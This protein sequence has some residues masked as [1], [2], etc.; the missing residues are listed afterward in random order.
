MHPSVERRGAGPA[1]RLRLAICTEAGHAFIRGAQ[2]ELDIDRIPPRLEDLVPDE[3][4]GLIATFITPSR[5]SPK[6]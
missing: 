3:G 6:S 5:R 1:E 4:Y 2:P